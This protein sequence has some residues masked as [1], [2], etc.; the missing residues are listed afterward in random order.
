MSINEEKYPCHD[1]ISG[2]APPVDNPLI[3]PYKEEVGGSSP[4]TPTTQK[5]LP[6]ARNRY[7][8]GISAYGT[9]A[10][11]IPLDTFRYSDYPGVSRTVRGQ[12]DRL[13]TV[14]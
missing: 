13:Q 8:T 2:S 6:R 11:I 10:K 5:P 9:A 1:R 7:T 14:C 12:P 3:F 4:S